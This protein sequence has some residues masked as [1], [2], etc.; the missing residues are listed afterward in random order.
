MAG[1]YTYKSLLAA[2]LLNLLLLYRDI[3][4]SI[5]GSRSQ[6]GDT[7]ISGA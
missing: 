5:D 6:N 7:R 1:G 2:I 4:D 3:S